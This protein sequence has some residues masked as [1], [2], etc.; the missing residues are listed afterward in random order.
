MV[1]ENRLL[2]RIF[3]PKRT[4]V[5]GEWRKLRVYNE[6]NDLYSPNI[7]RVIKLRR[8][9]WVGHVIRMGRGMV[10]TGFGEET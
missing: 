7:I 1:S 9:R 10:H 8:M 4:K 2:K 5:I 6:L 3:G